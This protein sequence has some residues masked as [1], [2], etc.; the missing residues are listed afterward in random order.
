MAKKKTLKSPRY[1]LVDY[2][3]NKVILYNTW[4]EL[5]D[6]INQNGWECFDELALVD[7][8]DRKVLDVEV[9]IPKW[10]LVRRKAKKKAE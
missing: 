3:E 8:Q 7:M 2:T 9:V 5:E 4:E 1:V 10:K 6:M